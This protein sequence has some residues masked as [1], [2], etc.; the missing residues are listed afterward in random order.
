MHTLHPRRRHHEAPEPRRGVQRPDSESHTVDG[1]SEQALGAIRLRT[2]SPGEGLAH[3]PT[4]G[5]QVRRLRVAAGLTQVELALRTGS[6]QPAVAHLEAGRRTPTLPTLERIA[7]A[8]GQDL[9]VVL[10]CTH[11]GGV[12]A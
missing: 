11:L 3:T 5:E 4:V 8:I 1:M 9:V 12:T 10:P 6:T 2:A 7:S